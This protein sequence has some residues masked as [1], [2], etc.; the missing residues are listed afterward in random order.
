MTSQQNLPR[1]TAALLSISIALLT[2]VVALVWLA[3]PNF[4]D[5]F[6][7]KLVIY[8]C[9]ISLVA[10]VVILFFRRRTLRTCI[11]IGTCVALFGFFSVLAYAFSR[12]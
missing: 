3:G 9:S 7:S 2:L 11:V 12:I 5:F 6:V 8:P 1:L 4:T 10:G